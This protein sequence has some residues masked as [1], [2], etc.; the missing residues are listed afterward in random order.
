MS[1]PKRKYQDALY[2]QFAR[3]GK[4]LGSPKRLEILDLLCQGERSVETL[5]REA[6]LSVANTSQH[7]QILRATHLVEADKRGL[8]VFYRIADPKVTDFFYSLRLLA[9]AQLAEVEQITRR[10]FQGKEDMEGV[11][12]DT[13][14]ERVATGAAVALDVRPEEEYTAGHIP[15]AISIPLSE[16]R[17]RFAELPRDREI[18]AY[19]RGPYC[20][21]SVEAVEILRAEGFRA[22]R[23]E[24]N[25]EWLQEGNGSC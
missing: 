18:V 1:S 11:D 13:L 4:A 2:D 20:V 3:I 24:A 17:R 19:C 9:E 5:A 12:K 22:I 21:L 10:F 15:G 14:L 7:L 8:H 23:I 25:Q 6:N 16:L